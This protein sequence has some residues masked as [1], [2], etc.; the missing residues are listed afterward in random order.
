MAHELGSD[1]VEWWGRVR[2]ERLQDSKCEDFRLPFQ[3]P[4]PPL[5]ATTP[6]NDQVAELFTPSDKDCCRA[7]LFPRQRDTLGETQLRHIPETREIPP[8]AET[9][10]RRLDTPFVGHP[11]VSRS[12]TVIAPRGDPE[13]GDSER[14]ASRKAHRA[15][16]EPAFVRQPSVDPSLALCRAIQKNAAGHL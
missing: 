3:R 10:S 7:Q 16:A 8:F 9:T 13:V 11:P 15:L 14:P 1:F 12:R 2:S 4:M 6:S 5:L